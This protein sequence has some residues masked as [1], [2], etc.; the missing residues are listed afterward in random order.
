M[1][2]PATS[3]GG[4]LCIYCEPADHEAAEQGVF[5]LRQKGLGRRSHRGAWFGRGGRAVIAQ[6]VEAMAAVTMRTLIAGIW[7]SR[8]AV[9]FGGN[10]PPGKT[11]RCA[12]GHIP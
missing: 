2:C 3:I 5:E 6:S 11:R 1:P 8:T 12:L 9:E 7:V 10:I 4:L